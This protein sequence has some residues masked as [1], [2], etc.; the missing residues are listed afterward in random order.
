MDSAYGENIYVDDRTIDSHIKRLRKKF[1]QVDVE[2]NEI[3]TLYGVGY[4]YRQ[5][6]DLGEH[7]HDGGGRPQ[8]AR[9]PDARG[10]HQRLARRV[11]GKR[12]TNRLRGQRQQTTS[13]AWPAA[14][15]NAAAP[16]TT[17]ETDLPR[18][19]RGPG[20]GGLGG[21]PPCRAG[22]GAPPSPGGS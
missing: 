12:Q 20:H 8:S 21:D 3:E 16:A 15:E 7:P 19:A 10:F 2:F 6:A 18:R 4:R 1:K 13:A 22:A 5:S 17:A 9:R 14:P 11:C